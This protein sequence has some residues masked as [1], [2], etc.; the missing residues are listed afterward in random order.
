M[1]L[2][3]AEDA[4]PLLTGLVHSGLSLI[5]LGTLCAGIGAWVHVTGDP[6]AAG[7]ALSIAL[8]DPDAGHDLL[9][10]KA[11][12]DEGE[13]GLALASGAMA[14]PGADRADMMPVSAHLTAAD[15]IEGSGDGEQPGFTYAG[16]EGGAMIVRINGRAI[17]P[18][19]SLTTAA[20][21]AQRAPS[22]LRRAPIAGLRER[23][24]DLWLPVKSPDGRSAAQEYAR[25]TQVSE[26]TPRVAL[27][28]GGLGINHRTT[29]QAIADLPAEVTLSFSANAD[30][31]QT[32]IDAARADGHEVLIEV[33]MES[34]E[35]DDKV[36][37]PNTLMT[38]GAPS[39]NLEALNQVL[40]RATGYF[41]IINYQGAR[42][43][44]NPEAVEPLMRTLEMRGV[45]M[46]EDASLAR[47]DFSTQ[48]EAHGT[49][50]TRADIVIDA[51]TQATLIEK[52]LARLES[53]A[54]ATGTA[55]GTGFAFPVTIDTVLTWSQQ[56]GDKGIAL[57][58]ASALLDSSRASAPVPARQAA[59][60]MGSP[61]PAG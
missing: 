20:S 8:F 58:P 18:G 39:A 12:F 61:G 60:G 24:G 6:A 40:S 35:F 29:L 27:V 11:R 50:Y 55:L 13:P 44:T 16:S 5:S 37:Q 51:D 48:A 4:S 9:P 26:L 15:L 54:L 57:V 17:A 33:A 22:P 32:L 1:S 49:F 25:P 7:P 56:L 10:L 53:E 52:E 46:I 47:S 28:V 42:F 30:G 36:A 23:V 2:H 34:Y 31:L 45:A 41:G 3:T 38:D 43:A 21:G 59:L 14:G 19:M